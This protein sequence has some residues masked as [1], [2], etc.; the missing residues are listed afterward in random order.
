[1]SDISSLSPAS[2][3]T[4]EEFIHRSEFWLRV[5]GNERDRFWE[6]DDPGRSYSFTASDVVKFTEENCLAATAASNNELLVEFKRKL[7][8]DSEMNKTSPIEGRPLAQKLGEYLVWIDRLFFFGLITHPTRR[9]GN[10]VADQPLI[11]LRF[12]DGIGDREGN[13]LNGIFLAKVGQMVVSLI[14]PSGQFKHF[15]KA[16]GTIAHELLHVYLHILTRENSAASYFRD[17]FDNEHGAKFQELLYFMFTKLSYWMPTIPYLKELA[18]ETHGNLEIML[19]R[20][21]ISDTDA[22]SQIYAKPA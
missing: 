11:T 4:V 2:R 14:E 16:V 10:L 22:R 21:A 5:P 18:A 1:M 8:T 3:A 15:E 7:Y 13:D 19:A 12:Q 17:I 20:P 6:M 9:E